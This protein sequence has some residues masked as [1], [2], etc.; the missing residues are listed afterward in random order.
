MEISWK[1]SLKQKNCNHLKEKLSQFQSKPRWSIRKLCSLPV[2]AGNCWWLQ[3]LSSAQ[4]AQG[5]QLLLNQEQNRQ[6]TY[7]CYSAMCQ[8]GH[9]S[10]KMQSHAEIYTRGDSP[11][12][13]V[14]LGEEDFTAGRGVVLSRCLAVV[15]VGE[16]DVLECP[17][18][19]RIR[20]EQHSNCQGFRS[21]PCCP[22][23][24][25]PQWCWSG[26]VCRVEV[27][28]PSSGRSCHAHEWNYLPLCV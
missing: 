28:A 21:Q 19:R 5:W 10:W 15:S 17:L 11:G 2:P 14:T 6:C 26:C 12:F 20:T 7:L 4:M 8:I 27:T 22:T 1:D 24:Q 23:P 16:E 3:T 25:F 9:R 13:S 18:V